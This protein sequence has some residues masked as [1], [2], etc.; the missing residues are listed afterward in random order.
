[1]ARVIVRVPNTRAGGIA[2]EHF[3]S[4]DLEQRLGC[5]HV[6]EL[7]SYL[8][9]RGVQNRGNMDYLPSNYHLLNTL[10]DDLFGT[11]ARILHFHND[12]QGARYPRGYVEL[13]EPDRVLKLSSAPSVTIGSGFSLKNT[14]SQYKTELD[15]G[16]A[17]AV[18]K[19][20]GIRIAIIDSGIEP[21]TVVHQS[22]RDLMSTAPVVSPV[23][24]L[25]HGTAMA[26]IMKDI[27]PDAEI[28]VI[29]VLETSDTTLFDLIA[30]LSTAVI[31]CKAHIV[32][33]SLGFENIEGDCPVCG[34]LGHTRSKVLDDHLT[35]LTDL[36]SSIP[37]NPPPSPIFVAATGNDGNPTVY[38][39]AAYPISMA[40][41]SRTTKYERSS[42]SNY[43]KDPDRFIL[44]P[45]GD[46]TPDA[47]GA[48]S[49][50]VGEGVDGS[51]TTY[52]LGTSVA[53]AYASGLLALYW[54]DK[55]SGKTPQEFIDAI[56]SECEKSKI[57]SSYNQKQ[58]GAGYLYYH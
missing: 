55:Y 46:S 10:D 41:G 32:N 28:H 16:A 43:G 21:G 18:T 40:I 6:E 36:H 49:E 29:R 42:F 58:H 44:M 38:Y 35:M 19:G 1:M 53:T 45:G 25:G 34:V 50:S 30:G 37:H 17:H 27:A 14:H 24:D 13:V 26:A 15:I 33:L 54:A 12:P 47:T 3:Q 2:S 52:C 31:D 11:I 48:P 56:L 5:S 20:A 4:S 22:Y 39:P 23:D 8:G 7:S 9:A 51:T 57:G